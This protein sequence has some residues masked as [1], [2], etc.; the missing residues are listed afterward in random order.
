MHP[1]RSTRTWRIVAL[2][3][4]T[5]PLLAC[6]F[7]QPVVHMTAQTPSWACPSP[8][9]LPFG[10]AGPVKEVIRRPRPT[11]TPTGPVTYEEEPV[12]FLEWEQEYGD[13]GGPPFP[14]PTPYVLVGTTYTLGQRVHLSPLYALVT[15]R[16]GAL[17]P[18]GRQLYLIDI[19][20]DN[21]LN[22][23]IAFAYPLQVSLRAISTADGRVQTSDAWRV[24]S[25][26]LQAVQGI[27]PDQIPPGRSSVQAPIL[28]PPGMPQTIEIAL[29][30]DPSFDPALSTTPTATATPVGLAPTPNTD[31][32]AAHPDLVV[33][34]FVAARP[35]DPPCADPGAMTP[36]RTDGAGVHGVADRPL[37]APPGAGRVVEVAL[38]QVGKPY[39]WGATGPAAF[40]CSGLM[41]WA[42]AQIGLRVP[43][44]TSADQYARLTPVSAADLQPGDL[45]FFA[46]RD[47][48]VV[49]HVGMVVG[50]L[51][52]DGRWDWVHAASP[53]LGVRTELDL[54]GSSFYGN[55]ATCRLCLVGFRTMR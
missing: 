47:A 26:S 23:P 41:V 31:L 3:L 36:W 13:L 6:T 27:L 52:G 29:R 24:S 28:A 25:E 11:I 48:G 40:D 15:A 39:I 22:T 51:N 17:Q 37:V 30:R 55:P 9:P 2:L 43:V 16:A 1:T 20:W 10:A 14:S 53:A 45:A 54:F 44:R 32:R 33:V 8:T 46:W 5:A 50:D 42:Y 7:A 19:T 34:Q 12:Y 38:A 49:S 18:D 35:I 21:P 4:V